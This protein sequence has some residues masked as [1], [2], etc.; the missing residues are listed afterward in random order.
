MWRCNPWRF[1]AR[2]VE[3]H[4]VETP[5][6]GTHGAQP[7]GVETHG[8]GSHGVETHGVWKHDGVAPA[9]VS[10][11]ISF[12]PMKLSA[13]MSV[14]ILSVSWILE[15]AGSYPARRT[16]LLGSRIMHSWL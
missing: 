16:N 9:Q 7:R 8:V 5:G 12:S 4:G 1:E 6:V 13:L 10:I 11:E 3:T 15:V 2:G 14:A